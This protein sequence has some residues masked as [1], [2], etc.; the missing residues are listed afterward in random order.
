MNGAQPCDRCGA[1]AATRL[2]DNPDYISGEAFAVIRCDS[3]GL[4]RTNFPYPDDALGRYYGETYYGDDG[5][6]FIGMMEWGVAQFREARVR[7]IERLHPTEGAVLDIGCGRGLILQRL[8]A[9]GWSATGTEMSEAL[10]AKLWREHRIRI[11]TQP[12]LAD[13]AL[14]AASQDVILMWH[15]LEHVT[16]P[17][18]TI[19]ECARLLKSDGTLLIEVPNL[20][21]WQ[22]KLGGGSW[23]HLDTPRHLY[24]FS[25][26]SLRELCAQ[27]GLQVVAETTLSLEQ[28]I[29]GMM[30]TLLNR[31][32]PEPNLLYRLLKRQRPTSRGVMRWGGIALTLALLP[33]VGAVSVPLEMLAVTAGRGA[34]IQYTLRKS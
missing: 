32:T 14:P 22:A 11:Y 30:Q 5:K 6:R 7:Q 3:C 15:S 29:Y 27:H 34:V 13:N 24:H 23:F 20:D 18:S 16:Q 8:H 31:V 1:Q 10:A 4:V 26:E 28:G 2:F 9:L 33:F 21:S 19:A 25:A 17:A 12:R